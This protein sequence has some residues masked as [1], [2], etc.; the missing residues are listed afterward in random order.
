MSAARLSLGPRGQWEGGVYALVS[1]A[2]AEGRAGWLCPP[3]IPPRHV[4]HQVCVIVLVLLAFAPALRCLPNA[5]LGA[6]VI[7]AF[8][9]VI[10]Q[11]TPKASTAPRTPP[12]SHLLAVASQVPPALSRVA[13]GCSSPA[14]ARQVKQVPKLWKLKKVDCAVWLATF[15]GILLL[16]VTRGM[17]LGI[18]SSLL[19]MVRLSA[20]R[21]WAELAASSY[22]CGWRQWD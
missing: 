17:V 11:V 5:T 21:G 16:G 15:L 1:G 6:I 20:V 14:F 13:G 3:D 4:C 18:C 19:V 12:P 7:L 9:S 10:G 22:G 8:K 2:G